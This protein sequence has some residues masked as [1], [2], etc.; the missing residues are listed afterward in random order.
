MKPLHLAVAMIVLSL[1]S[2]AADKWKLV[3]SDEF[4]GLIGSAPNAANWAYDLG[5]NGWGNNELEAYTDRR[6][7]SRIENGNLVI[8][9]IKE[10]FTGK[11]GKERNYT[12]ARLKTL[13]K[14]SWTY[15]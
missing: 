13:G 4:S 6:A 11:D 10:K 15:G 8:E 9:A 3:W 12:S 7:N 14:E 2:I 1:H 5:G